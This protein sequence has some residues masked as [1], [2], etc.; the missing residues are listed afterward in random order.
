MI[1]KPHDTGARQTGELLLDIRDLV[2]EA[3]NSG[4]WQPIVKGISLS[5]RRGEVLGLIGD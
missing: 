1:S 2:V 3:D 5:L 4:A